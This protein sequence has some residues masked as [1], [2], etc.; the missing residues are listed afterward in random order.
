MTTATMNDQRNPTRSFG[1]QLARVCFM[2]FGARLRNSGADYACESSP[3][4]GLLGARY[5]LPLFD[6][7]TNSPR[8]P[9]FCTCETVITFHVAYGIIKKKKEMRTHGN[10]RCTFRT[11]NSHGGTM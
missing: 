7:I 10:L 9:H 4:S 8:H 2:F 6:G 1:S 11:F 3:R 5:H